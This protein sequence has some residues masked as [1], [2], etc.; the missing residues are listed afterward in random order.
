[1]EPSDSLAV[2]VP[3][4]FPRDH[5][6]APPFVLDVPKDWSAVNAPGCLVALREQIQPGAFRANLTISID[7]VPRQTELADA[8]AQTLIDLEREQSAVRIEIE[9]VVA[10]AD[11]AASMRVQT[12]QPSELAYRVLQ[13]QF[14]FFAPDAGGDT[15]SLF[16]LIGS[17]LEPD[18]DRYMDDFVCAA[19]TFSFT[20]P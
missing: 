18:S 11:D 13:A 9:K 19:Q 6:P 17:C 8:A 5:M 20:A 10:L 2:R 14:L 7:Y 4:A 3:F 1:M 12:F 15:R 16:T